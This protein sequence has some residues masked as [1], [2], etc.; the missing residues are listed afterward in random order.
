[1]DV[2]EERSRLER[3]LAEMQRQAQR[4]EQLLASPFSQKAP[5]A[6][7][8]KERDKLAV[9]NESMQKLMGQLESLS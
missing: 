5:P 4:L 8:Q 7:V 3:E 6:V 9:V 1:V 2:E